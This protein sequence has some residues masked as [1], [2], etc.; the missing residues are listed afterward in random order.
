LTDP[1]RGDDEMSQTIRE[2]VVVPYGPNHRTELDTIAGTPD[3]YKMQYYGLPIN[4]TGLGVRIGSYKL[5]DGRIMLERTDK[6][7]PFSKVLIFANV[8]EYQ[9][10]V[11]AHNADC[12]ERD[13]ETGRYARR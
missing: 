6:Y 7:L 3:W 13:P 1:E 4:G 2:W 9:E 11:K 5:P 10:W 8:A 12:P